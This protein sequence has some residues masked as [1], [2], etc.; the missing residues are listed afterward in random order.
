MATN[1]NF[2]L[3]LVLTLVAL[4][5][6]GQPLFQSTP[7][8]V[9]GVEEHARSDAVE[10]E[11]LDEP[12]GS[13]TFTTITEVEPSPCESWR[14]VTLRRGSRRPQWTRKLIQ[15]DVSPPSHVQLQRRVI[16]FRGKRK[17]LIR[18]SPE[19]AGR[20]PRTRARDVSPGAKPTHGAIPRRSVINTFQS[21]RMVPT[22]PNPLHNSNRSQVI[23]P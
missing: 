13:P 12:G 15:G 19:L 7:N 6:F 8:F 17:L 10:K 21:D 9:A 18:P 4:M 3:L 20:P 22:G 2:A 1:W 14:L 16:N 11:S 5:T 23:F